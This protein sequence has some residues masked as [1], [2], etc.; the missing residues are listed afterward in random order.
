[1]GE[2][3]RGLM[4]FLVSDRAHVLAES[5]IFFA[6]PIGRTAHRMLYLLLSTMNRG[7][8]HRRFSEQTIR[9]FWGRS[10]ILCGTC[11]WSD[12]ARF[13]P[14]RLQPG[15]RLRFYAKHFSVVE[16]DTT[17]YALPKQD[18]V[19]AWAN[20]VADNFAFDVKAHRS[21]TLQDR[22]VPNLKDKLDVFAAFRETTAPFRERNQLRALLF[23]FPPWIAKEARIKDYIE[24]C[25][26]HFASDLVAVEFRHGSWFEGHEMGA[27]LKWLRELD[28]VH[29]IVDEPQVGV[30][31]VPLI[32][33]AT[34]RRL[35][36]V[37]FHGR[38]GDTWAKPNL[39]S[40]GERFRYLYS[41]EELRG[42][43]PMLQELDS[44][45]LEVHALMNNNFDNYAIRGAIA[46]QRLL[47]VDATG[48]DDA[49]WDV[50]QAEWLLD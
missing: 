6:N 26:E 17:Y 39:S 3:L 20:A 38:N 43:V 10:M 47:G 30:G 1:M 15:D 42:F 9:L 14:R 16:V 40:S 23:Q 29:V 31:C 48:T 13:Y 37:R 41:Q 50:E 28:A 35:A 19:R 8:T 27:T 12:H 18:T 33:E 44:Q 45:V 22:S 11:A 4:E 2:R 24:Q 34:N 7:F 5:S 21:M 46:L 25:R 49:D 32:A 36:L